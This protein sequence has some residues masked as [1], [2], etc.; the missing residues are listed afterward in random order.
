M[1]RDFFSLFRGVP[2]ET[3][4]PPPHICK[5][6]GTSL[7]PFEV[8]LFRSHVL[9]HTLALTG[10]FRKTPVLHLASI[11]GC[12]R[13]KWMGLSASFVRYYMFN[14]SLTLA[15]AHKSHIVT[16][17]KLLSQ[18]PKLLS[19]LYNYW[20]NVKI[21]VYITKLW[22]L[23]QNYCHCDEIIVSVTTRFLCDGPL[24]SRTTISAS[25]GSVSFLRWFWGFFV[26][27]CLIVHAR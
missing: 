17:T 13:R 7:P 8:R 23:W 2:R 26:S 1:G 20:H 11:L 24:V 16:V 21:I 4:S 12:C 22:S 15:T 10:Y 6:P 19:L 25:S 14:C 27:I 18:W 5:F 9:P 3:Q